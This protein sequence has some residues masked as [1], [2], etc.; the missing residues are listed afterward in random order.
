MSNSRIT[1]E[2]ARAELERRSAAKAELQRRQFDSSLAGSISKIPGMAAGAAIGLPGKMLD[3]AMQVPGAAGKVMTHPIDA[4]RDVLGGVA[5]GS[6]HLAA[7]LGEAGQYLGDN[8]ATRAIRKKIPEWMKVIPDVNV[9]E[10]MGLDQNNPVDLGGMIQSKD[11]NA[12]LSGIGQYGLGGAAGGARMLPLMAANAA[13]GAIQAEP[14]QRLKGGVEGAVSAALPVGA[15]RGINAMRPSKMLAGNLSPAELQANLEAAQGTTTGLG[16]VIG[17]PGL[18]RA[19]ENI[20]PRIPGSGAD[21]AMQGTATQLIE[22]GKG[23]LEKL[24]QGLP[25][26]DMGSLLQDA[27]KKAS[28]EATSEKNAN[29]KNVNDIADKAGVVVPRTQFKQKAQNILDEVEKSPE[30]KRELS[31][32]VL[33]DLK[34]Y[35]AGEKGNTLRLSNIFKGKLN[36]K[37][38]E[39]YLSGKKYEYGL[40]KELRDALGGDI[41]TT[42]A[43]TKNKSLKDAYD[44]AMSE[45]GSKYKPFEDPDITKFTRE[46]GDPDLILSHFLKGGANDRGTLLAKVTDK[47]PPEARNLPAFMHLSKALEEGQLNPMKLRTLYKDLGKKQKETLIPDAAMRKTLDKY[48]KAIGMNTEAFSTMANPKTGQRLSDMIP[49]LGAMGGYQ[50]GSSIGGLPGGLIGG[51]AGMVLPGMAGKAATRLL[52]SPGVRESLVKA[53]MKAKTK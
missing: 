18:K 49:T 13:T 19:Y 2:M 20:L 11:P 33:A 50:I 43:G 10:E 14:G 51:A 22:Q 24:G 15:A 47:L 7:A 25:G 46:G 36:D 52:T 9:R 34:A 45:Y 3:L 16:D 26:G 30:L 12:L 1:P 35:A 17:S 41:D 38:T 28:R 21:T 31:P 39:A 29:F 48:T 27:L 5:K 53:I 37:A 40:I 42:I 23:H 44:T 32:D 6:Q 4:T 8:A